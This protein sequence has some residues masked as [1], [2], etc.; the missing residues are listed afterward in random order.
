MANAG[1]VEIDFAAETARFTSELKKVRAD[2]KSLQTDVGQ[3]SKS[4]SSFGTALK[5]SV[6]GTAVIA[7]FRAIVKATEESEAATAQLESAVK[8]ASVA[9]RLSVSDFQAFAK[10][11]QATTTFTDEAVA[12][13]ETI[14]L[15]F[16]S[17]SG[18]TIL[19]ATSAVLDLST[20]LGT[21]LTSS[22]KLVGRALEDPTKGMSALARAGVVFSQSQQAIIKSLVATGQKAE[23]QALILKELERRYG[24]AAEAARNTLGGALAALGNQFG[25]LFEGDKDSFKKATSSINA[26]TTAL[27]DPKVKQG[28]DNL[29]SAAS[30]SLGVL[31][32][33][34]IALTQVGSGIGTFFAPVGSDKSA[35]EALQRE[36]QIRED[37]LIRH[38]VSGF[39]QQ[40]ELDNEK[41][42]IE[43][44]KQRIEIARQIEASTARRVAAQKLEPVS[45]TV[46]RIGGEADDDTLAKLKT[47]QD[48]LDLRQKALTASITSA[49][50]FLDSLDK[51]L[52]DGEHRLTELNELA[53]KQQREAQAQV[54]QDSLDVAVAEFDRKLRLE[55]ELTSAK[56][57]EE[58][59]RVVI[60]R[61]AAEER[62]AIAL[63]AAIKSVA[64][65]GFI[66]GG[67][68]NANKAIELA[69]KAAA[70]KQIIIDTKTAVMKTL[71]YFGGT[72]WGYAAAAA[73][74]AF[75]ALQI[76]GVLSAD[77]TF[78]VNVP[79]GN[80]ASTQVGSSVVQ[81]TTEQAATRGQ[82][83]IQI[84]GSG[85]IGP[86]TARIIAE[87]VKDQVDHY[88]VRI[89]GKNSGQAEDL[90][91]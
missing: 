18:Q 53:R 12:G 82:V 73:V 49:G 22:A 32:R 85:V 47:Q 76:K 30:Q 1:T 39:F 46:S 58:R 35:V 9:V 24:G 77:S 55:Q 84:T 69:N 64:V 50:A 88:D 42:Y 11:M 66:V 23:A 59:R 56:L 2:L 6:A 83:T 74:A 36:L 71:S 27:N 7:G 16:K 70:I 79:T 4:L 40:Q 10:Q 17:L 5:T 28:F 87:A 52:G 89:I 91:T 31:A 80:F 3:I 60:E 62:K 90:K 65:L 86:E 14:L 29:I 26:L 20:R 75:G 41:A 68:K 45:V 72:P 43:T 38:R 34:G 61:A 54:A 15:A 33:L 21:D 51:Q 37:I 78:N 48:I 13:V 8:S 44:L 25:D 63:D 81:S 57:E 67:H 19:N